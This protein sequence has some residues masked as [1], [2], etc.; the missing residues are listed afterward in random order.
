MCVDAAGCI[1][2]YHK[3]NFNAC[4]MA[5]IKKRIQEFLENSIVAEV[6]A[7]VQTAVYGS[8]LSVMGGAANG[9][10]ISCE[11]KSIAC[12]RADNSG[13]TNYGVACAGSNNVQCKHELEQNAN[14]G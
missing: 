9:M 14:C 6:T 1:M 2:C 7:D 8:D 12:A 4:F 10:N 5:Q 13:C 3:F 11:N